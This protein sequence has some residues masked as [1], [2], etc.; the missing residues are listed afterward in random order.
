[1]H[2]VSGASPAGPRRAASGVCPAPIDG[3]SPRAETALVIAAL[4]VFVTLAVARAHAHPYPFYDD[5]GYLGRAEDIH[6]LGG[7]WALLRALYGGS[8]L[9]A[10]RHPLYLALL[11]LVA[12]TDEA[13]HRRAQMLGIALGG[14][15][16]LATWWTTRRLLGAAV[17]ALTLGFLAVNG[18]LLEHS[19]REA[20][21]AL[22]VALWVL[23]V[24]EMVR[25]DGSRWAWPLAGVWAGLAYLCKGTGLLLPLSLGLALLLAR[26]WRVLTS[27]P[28]WGFALTFLGVA[29]PL[30][31]RNL[32]AYGSPFF[33]VNSRYL[34]ANGLPDFAELFAPGA[35][36]QLPHSLRDYLAQASASDVLRRVGRGLLETTFS[37]GDALALAS[38]RPGGVLHLL[39][40]ALGLG[41]AAVAIRAAWQRRESWPGRLVLV[42]V[43]VCFAFF[44]AYDAVAGAA[45]YLLPV[46]AVLSAVAAR[47]LLVWA[48]EG[49][50]WHLRRAALVLALPLAAVTAL[51]AGPD[52]PPGFV[53]AQTWL[54]DH[55]Q[56]GE[57]FAID[58]R[59]HLQPG[60]MMPGRREVVVSTSWR[61]EPVPVKRMLAHLRSSEV[62]YLVIDGGSRATA[63]PG[64]AAPPRYFFYDTVPALAD[65][66][67]PREGWPAPLAVAYAGAEQPRRWLVLDLGPT[68]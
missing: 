47:D 65:G 26:G 11:S 50:V 20:C 17:A 14:V 56:I 15:G 19:A 61:G 59:T 67:L 13:Y 16:L 68:P 8:F 25:G 45:R 2:S 4:A 51:A 22:L 55:V 39:W 33:N 1:V 32:R 9:E 63:L 35:E 37:L 58:S 38:P 64:T 29:S 21:D 36:A 18:T 44:V 6:R 31:V 12:G 7:P 57:G 30:L 49:S 23:A 28:A 5:V 53:E 54:R 46:A 48:T 27:L 34:W 66:A 3:P 40:V 24:G 52:T 10:N 62:R 41:V 43:G 60:W 42:H